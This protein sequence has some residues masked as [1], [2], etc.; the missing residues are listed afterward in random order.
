MGTETDMKDIKSSFTATETNLIWLIR[1][2]NIKS[3]RKNPDKKY[4]Y[5]LPCTLKEITVLERYIESP[6]YE[7]S[8]I[9]HLAV[10]SSKYVQFY[11]WGKCQ[12]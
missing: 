4:N 3:N 6:R 7:Y 8:F 11:F 5:S 10:S 12:L 9:N 2:F 1:Q